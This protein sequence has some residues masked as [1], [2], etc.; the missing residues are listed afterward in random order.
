MIDISDGHSFAMKLG[1]RWAESRVPSVSCL[2][3]DEDRSD[4]NCSRRVGIIPGL[5]TGP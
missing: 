3:P 5:C 1:W 2:D 4:P